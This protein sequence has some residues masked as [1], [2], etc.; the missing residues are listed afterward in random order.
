MNLRRLPVVE[1]YQSNKTAKVANPN[2]PI[3][4]LEP[5]LKIKQVEIKAREMHMIARIFFTRCLLVCV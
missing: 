2:V 1:H 3:K 5:N 4:Q